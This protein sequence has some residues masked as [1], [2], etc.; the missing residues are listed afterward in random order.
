MPVV[1][2][3]IVEYKRRNIRFNLVEGS[4][5]VFGVWMILFFK[6]NL[7]NI[8]WVPAIATRVNGK[9]G[10]MS[11]I[12]LICNKFKEVRR[13]IGLTDTDWADVM[14]VREWYQ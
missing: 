6:G 8:C 11:D 3:L 5:Y 9:A 14:R 7:W 12:M 2:A 4:A 1:L 13:A 10:H